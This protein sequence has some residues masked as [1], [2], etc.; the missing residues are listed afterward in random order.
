MR[1]RRD[2]GEGVM[3]KK[4]QKQMYETLTV[5]VRTNV[6][7][8]TREIQCGFLSFWKGTH[9]DEKTIYTHQ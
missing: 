5:Q 1:E 6:N 4:T 7:S 3:E 2:N 9:G 8:S